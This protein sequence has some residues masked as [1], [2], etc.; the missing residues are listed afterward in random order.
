[1]SKIISSSMRS[2]V[3]RKTNAASLWNFSAK[4]KGEKHRSG[5][6]HVRRDVRRPTFRPLPLYLLFCCSWRPRRAAIMAE[7]SLDVG[8]IFLRKEFQALTQGFW[9]CGRISCLGDLLASIFGWVPTRYYRSFVCI[10]ANLLFF[11]FGGSVAGPEV[12]EPHIRRD[13]LSFV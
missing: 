4:R 5:I 9:L 13:Y 1:M 6:R 3:L 11:F 8:G 10:I 12:R 7:I 2:Y